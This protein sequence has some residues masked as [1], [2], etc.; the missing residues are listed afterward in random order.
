MP[1]T[2][3]VERLGDGWRSPLQALLARYSLT[4]CEVGA[5]QTIPHSYW[6]APEAGLEHSRVWVRLDTPVHSV[7]HESSHVIC[8]DE[9]RRERLLSDAG[10]D[11]DEENAV[12]WLQIALADE[13]PGFGR[14]RLMADMDRWG[15]TFRLGSAEAWFDREAED[16]RRWLQ[17]YGIVDGDGRTTG[18]KRR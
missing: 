1:D 12:C 5:G 2:L 8:M 6:G 7:L 16:A 14:R 15:Y 4:M 13:L 11:H 18:R 3:G 9:A 10:G 17:R